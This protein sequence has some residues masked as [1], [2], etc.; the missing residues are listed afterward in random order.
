MNSIPANRVMTT[1]L[2]PFRRTVLAVLALGAA[3]A[4]T[5]SRSLGVDILAASGLP[6]PE[7]MRDAREK[8]G[9]T[10]DQETAIDKL[11]SAAREEAGP[12]ERSVREQQEVFVKLVRDGNVKPADAEAAL[13]KL[14]DAEAAVKRLQLRTLI[15]VRKVLTPDQVQKLQPMQPGKPSEPGNLPAK[16]SAK[17]DR[18][19]KAIDTLGIPA[20]PALHERGGE[21]EALLKDGKVDA[22]EAAIDKL[23]ADTQVDKLDAAAEAQDFSKFEPGNTDIPTLQ[24]RF[25]AVTEKAKDVIS[26]PLLRDLL[27]AKDAFEDAKSNQDATRVGRILTYAEQKLGMK[28]A[29]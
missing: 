7:A 26:L 10:T 19:R 14:L 23:I 17:V 24:E 20:T 21:I 8:L 22:A 15:E 3:V 28:P 11:M 18:L 6:Q 16:L 27:K 4:A 9:L 25:E 29:K 2:R 12:L 1:K 13:A 5:P